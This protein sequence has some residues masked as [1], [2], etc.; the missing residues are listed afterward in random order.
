MDMESEGEERDSDE[1]MVMVDEIE[2][3]KYA[4]HAPTPSQNLT[5]V[6]RAL[7][8]SKPILLEGSPGV[9]KSSL[10][11]TL[12]RMTGHRLLRINLSE[13]TD[14]ADLL[15]A[16]LP[17]GG[18]SADEEKDDANKAVAEAGGTMS[19]TVSQSS[20]G[21]TRKKRKR[22]NSSSSSS[23][24]VALQQEPT[25]KE[26]AG[27]ESKSDSDGA[28]GTTPQFQWCDGV[29]LR[30]LKAGDWVLLDELNLAPQSVLEGLNACLDH[31]AEVY[32][33]EIDQT[34]DCPKSFRIFAT[35]NP[36]QEG[37]GRKGLPRSFLNRFTKVYVDSLLQSDLVF[38]AAH[39]FDLLA[40]SED[41]QG[42][43]CSKSLIQ[44]M[45]RFNQEMLKRTAGRSSFGRDGAP[46]DFNLRDVFRWCTLTTETARGRPLRGEVDD[47]EERWLWA[48]EHV[49][50]IYLQ[51]MR[52][53][54]DRAVV[55]ILCEE[56]FSGMPP[57]IDL[58]PRV[59]VDRNVVSIGTS[60]LRR[61]DRDRH[62]A[63][64]AA[65]VA[66]PHSLSRPLRH[67]MTCVRRDWP[68]LLVGPTASG[69]TTALRWLA[70][71]A[72]TTLHEIALSRATDAA[73]LLGCYEQTLKPG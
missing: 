14:I 51:R 18:G 9:G 66:V 33:P 7:Q 43:T 49:D 68:T 46:W 44:R 69:K 20:D 22:T 24:E 67:M 65:A 27:S 56:I 15:G 53:R 37:G 40:V 55:S 38:I 34:F 19:T 52:T 72:G 6:M 23:S 26:S 1:E 30:A 58:F 16:N 36:L 48:L 28:A 32:I 2:P 4:L 59:D 13:Q 57:S 73:D 47:E 35:Q 63:A 50:V 71:S 45:V 31:R 64:A 70:S 8:L 25:R 42:I 54:S 29:F 21:G 5:R 3:P 11:A 61:G 12:A 60:M 62:P 41:L 17:V 10:I 39:R